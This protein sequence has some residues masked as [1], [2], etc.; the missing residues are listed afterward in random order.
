[1]STYLDLPGTTGHVVGVSFGAQ[2]T[3]VVVT[4]L[5][6]REIQHATVS[7]PDH[8]EAEDAARWLVDLIAQ[9]AESAQGPLRQIVAAVPG[10]VRGGTE[11]FGPTES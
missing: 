11:I 7:T 6:G 2:T 4:D 1:M 5:R 9:A 10:R 8:Q 3:G